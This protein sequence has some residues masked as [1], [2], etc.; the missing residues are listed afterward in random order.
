MITQWIRTGRAAHVGGVMVLGIEALEEMKVVT[1]WDNLYSASL[2]LMFV[3][4][5]LTRR[6]TVQLPLYQSVRNTHKKARS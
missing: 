5:P 6:C 3:L 1:H 4:E 2:N